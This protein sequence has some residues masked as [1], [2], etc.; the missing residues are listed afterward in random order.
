[1]G[2]QRLKYDSWR[3]ETSART[4]VRNDAFKL[5]SLH[6]KER[7]GGFFIKGANALY[8]VDRPQVASLSSL[9]VCSY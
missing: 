9:R 6:L 8:K 4:S 5:N 3:K 2:S 7:F 1:M